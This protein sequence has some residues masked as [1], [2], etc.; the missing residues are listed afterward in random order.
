MIPASRINGTR[1]EEESLARR[2]YQRGSLV[3][4]NGIWTAR[5]REDVIG[6]D[7]RLQRVRRGQR[8]GLKRDFPTRKLAQRQFDLLLS[9]VNSLNYSAVRMADFQTFVERWKTDV[10]PQSELSTQ[11]QY[12]LHLNRWLLPV[13][14]SV[15]MDRIG[16]E[17]AQMVIASMQGK[18]AGYARDVIATLCSIM[19]TARAWRYTASEIDRRSLTFPKRK[20]AP[21]RRFFS[22]QQITAIVALAEMKW[23]E[24]PWALAFL[25]AAETGMREGEILGL[26]WPDFDFEQCMVAVRRKVWYTKPG[27]TKTL[28]SEAVLPVPQS[29]VE[30][31][32]RYRETRWKRNEGQWLFATRHGKPV[33]PCQIVQRKLWAV[34]DALKIERCGMHAFRHG[35]ASMLVDAG[36]PM[37]VVRDQLRHT[38]VKMTLSVYSHVIGSAQREAVERLSARLDSVGLT[39]SI[40]GSI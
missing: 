5:W 28:A 21:R 14:G 24:Q 35:H 40:G 18:T 10:L 12:K 34:L 6:A 16:N 13:L 31:L 7:G 23:P 26:Q 19:K 36:E 32:R 22:E 29:L 38:D 3:L 9:R 37:T 11:K 39:G 2:R 20:E 30:R 27:A 8:I 4:R 1:R 17:Q 25:L 33:C 15:R